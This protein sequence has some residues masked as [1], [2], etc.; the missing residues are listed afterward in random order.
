MLEKASA[1]A[2]SSSDFSCPS[3]HLPG[4]PSAL[5]PVDYGPEDFLPSHP[6]GWGFEIFIQEPSGRYVKSYL[7]LI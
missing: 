5:V 3:A 4:D 1:A 6:T 7:F 2:L